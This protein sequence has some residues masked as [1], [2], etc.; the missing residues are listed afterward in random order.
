MR[1]ADFYKTQLEALIHSIR[2]PLSTLSLSVK[3]LEQFSTSQEN[4]SNVF[5]ESL[6]L[7]K[8]SVRRISHKIDAVDEKLS[9]TK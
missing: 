2:S 6:E 7:I 8:S 5:S 4:R 9:E 3:S 1:D